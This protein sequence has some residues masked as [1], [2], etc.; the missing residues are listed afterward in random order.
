ML[1]K[2]L[3][4]W[5]S[6][7]ESFGTWKEIHP[8]M[9]SCP[10]VLKWYKNRQQLTQSNYCPNSTPWTPL[11]DRNNH[12]F[13]HHTATGIIAKIVSCI[14]K[15]HSR[16]LGIR[17][18]CKLHAFASVITWLRIKCNQWRIQGGQFGATAPPNLCGAPMNGALCHK[19]APFWCPWK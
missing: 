19:C 9:D 8:T 3:H 18:T 14:V 16:F 11:V 4:C 12:D 1:V 6:F 13:I 17:T 5:V 7:R 2:L 15:R 10:V